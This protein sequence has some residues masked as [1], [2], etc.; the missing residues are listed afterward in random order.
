MNMNKVGRRCIGGLSIIGA[1]VW[2]F[3]AKAKAQTAEET[4]ALAPANINFSFRLL[5]ELVREEPGK[6]V[7][8]S[9]FSASVALQMAWNGARGQT[10]TEM[11]RALGMAGL[12]AEVVNRANQQLLQDIGRETNVILTTAN[13]LWYRKGI[14]VRPEFIACNQQ[15][16]KAVV[17]GL[18]FNDPK[19]VG[20]INGWVAEQT[21]GRIDKMIAG[22]LDPMTDLFLANA[23]YFKGKWSEP[24]DAKDTK[25]RAFHMRGGGEK[26]TPMMSQSRKFLYRKGSG[27]QAV[28]LAYQGWNLWMYVF[29]PDS[30]STPEKLLTVLNGD[31]WRRVTRPGFEDRQGT[32]VLPKFKLDHEAELTNALSALG[33]KTAFDQDKAD[34]AGMA[35]KQ[36]YISSVLQKA[37]VEVKEE[38]TEAAAVTV[39]APVAMGIEMNP[40]TPFEMI[41]DRPFLFLIEDQTTQAIL[42][43]GIVQEPKI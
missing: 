7:F 39:I 2:I 1:A 25:D 26:Q 30:G 37:F 28:R 29:L 27:Y 9:P 21:H 17:D 20:I 3:A 12:S 33:M 32:L 43:M 31:K 10:K 40:P 23:V 22:P 14:P 35:N 19:S 5:N 13:A 15:F 8:I 11:E 41:V 36:L 18:D 6:N 4:A 24:F 42:F 38:G 34:F 16:Y